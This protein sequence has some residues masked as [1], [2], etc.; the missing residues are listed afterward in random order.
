M[1]PNPTTS[2]R[3]QQRCNI[4]AGSQ[5]ALYRRLLWGDCC[6][7]L[8]PPPNQETFSQEWHFPSDTDSVFEWPLEFYVQIYYSKRKRRGCVPMGITVTHENLNWNLHGKPYNNYNL[9]WKRS[10]EFARA[11]LLTVDQPPKLSKLIVRSRLPADQQMLGGTILCQSSNRRPAYCSSSDTLRSF[12]T[13][14]LPR[15]VDATCALQ[16][17]LP[18]SKHTKCPHGNSVGVTYQS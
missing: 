13:S 18:F 7:Y 4:Q 2:I 16:S 6:R 14:E 5:T 9:H 3:Y 12:L 11:H 1:S 15:T 8:C 10:V 17:M